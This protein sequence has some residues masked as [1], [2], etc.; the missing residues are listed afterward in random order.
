MGLLQNQKVILSLLC[1][2]SNSQ[3]L[4]VAAPFTSPME[5]T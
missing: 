5:R 2:P 3:A 4:F 1:M